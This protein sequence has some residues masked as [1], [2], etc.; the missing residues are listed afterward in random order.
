MRIIRFTHANRYYAKRKVTRRLKAATVNPRTLR[1]TRSKNYSEESVT[2]RFYGNARRT[3]YKRYNFHFVSKK[4]EQKKRIA[5][6]EAETMLT[7]A[8]DVTYFQR[9]R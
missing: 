9:L 1:S 6:G 8:K 3:D 4:T 2:E 7:N 5:I